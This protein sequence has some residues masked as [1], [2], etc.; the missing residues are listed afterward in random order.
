VRRPV[1]QVAVLATVAGLAAM[2]C[3]PDTV[4]IA[5]R[6]RLG[7]RAVYRVMVSATSVTTLADQPARSTTDEE[8]F[9]AT[10]EVL[11]SSSGG[12]RVRVKLT[13]PGTEARTYVVRLD[14]AAQLA[15]VQLVEGLPASSLGDLGLSEIFPAAAAAP[16]TRPLRPGERW[17]IDAPITLAGST[18]RI[19]GAGRVASLGVIGGRNVVRIEC[20]YRL[21]VD[22]T[23]ETSRLLGSESTTSTATRRLRDGTIESET[24][25]T[26]ATYAV[27]VLP[28]KGTSGPVIPGT[29]IVHIQSRTTRIR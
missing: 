2:S 7:S 17:R 26:T 12:S 29:L 24:A 25:T 21:P 14:R 23:S 5:Y 1:A 10:H 27:S 18:T 28:P 11:E 6:P 16:P 19:H 3:R 22:R 15:E 13:S 8:V 20:S 9:T 4:R